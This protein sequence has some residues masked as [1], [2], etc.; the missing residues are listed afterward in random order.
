MTTLV[1]AIAQLADL[2]QAHGI[3]YTSERDHSDTSIA[4]DDRPYKWAQVPAIVEQVAA[5][6]DSWMKLVDAELTARATRRRLD[7]ITA[8]YY[9][10]PDEAVRT[11]LVSL[12]L[13]TRGLHE[14]KGCDLSYLKAAAKRAV[15][16][17]GLKHAAYRPEAGCRASLKLKQAVS[18]SFTQESY[19]DYTMYAVPVTVEEGAD[20]A[21]CMRNLARFAAA[22]R[23]HT[24]FAGSGSNY[25]AELITTKAGYVVVITDR[26]SI[27]D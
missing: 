24:G 23:S 6:D 9:A 20:S 16:N 11:Y 3:A 14:A 19:A 4:W 8:S 25:S 27:A 21:T 15:A 22:C 2:F 26:S 5:S 10:Q 17:N 1:S 13:G 7:A 18:F 12:D